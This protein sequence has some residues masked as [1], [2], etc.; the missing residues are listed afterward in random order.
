MQRDEDI[1]GDE[2]T[3]QTDYGKIERDCRNGKEQ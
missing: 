2:K 3:M 1:M